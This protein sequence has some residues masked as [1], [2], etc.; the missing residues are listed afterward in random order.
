MV[1]S[2]LENGD[3]PNVMV[4]GPP[5]PFPDIPNPLIESLKAREGK[6]PLIYACHKLEIEI[7][8][9]LLSKG[10]DP[11]LA[12]K[13]GNTPLHHVIVNHEYSDDTQ[14]EVQIIKLLLGNGAN[15]NLKN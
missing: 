2:L 15:V 10:A 8:K 9:L 13:N 7:I 12:D 3:D 5:D 14:D 6:T 1:K 4:S 11:N